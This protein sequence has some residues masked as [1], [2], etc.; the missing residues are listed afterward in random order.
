MC[1][2]LRD[3]ILCRHVSA[4]HSPMTTS[5]ST[6][7]TATPFEP[8]ARHAGNFIHDPTDADRGLHVLQDED[9]AVQCLDDDGPSTDIVVEWH[10]AQAVGRK[11][12]RG[13]PPQVLVVTNHS[14]SD[15]SLAASLPASAGPLRLDGAPLSLGKLR[16]A[17]LPQDATPALPHRM[18]SVVTFATVAV[19]VPARSAARVCRVRHYPGPRK[20]PGFVYC[21]LP[22]VPHPPACLWS[23]ANA[24]QFPLAGNA[25]CT[26][27]FGGRG[28]HRGPE[29][30][31]SADFRAA[32]GT[33][34][35]SV[36][37]GTVTAV[38]D[39]RRLGAPHVDL[40]PEAN[41][42]RVRRADGVLAL[43]VHCAAGSARVREGDKVAVGAHLADVGDVG[44]GCGAHLHLQINAHEGEGAETV[45]WGFVDRRHGAVLPVAGHVY[46]PEG[47]VG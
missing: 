30:H 36:F 27:G 24:V 17:R 15:A 34:I 45:V 4:T 38:C 47:V 16:R 44:F 39:Q 2:R 9:I 8:C 41:A 18:G 33:P 10:D 6:D 35:F 23:P 32:E 5:P 37:A 7:T 43:Y 20:H 31:H 25:L 40:L 12:K 22:A 29:S 46:G 21:V 28:T 42:V 13:P 14:G 1:G 3:R 19:T 11:R 26:Q